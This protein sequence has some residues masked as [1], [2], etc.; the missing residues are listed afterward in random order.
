MVATLE[1]KSILHSTFL[2]NELF[3]FAYII[4]IVGSSFLSTFIKIVG[5]VGI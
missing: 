5:I 3:Y 2:F 1:F 4:K